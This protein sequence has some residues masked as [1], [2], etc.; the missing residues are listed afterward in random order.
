[1]CNA[2]AKQ[3]IV[4]NSVLRNLQHSVAIL[5]LEP[6]LMS[7]QWIIQEIQLKILQSSLF[8][9]F[10][11]SAPQLILQISIVLRTGLISKSFVF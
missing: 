7:N 2:E 1:M 10:L 3:I 4:P 11:E 8:E 9:A 6:N 5:L